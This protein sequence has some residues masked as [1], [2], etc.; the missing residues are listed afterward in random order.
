MDNSASHPGQWI[1]YRSGSGGKDHLAPDVRARI[2]EDEAV[3][4]KAQGLLLCEVRVLVYEREAIPQVSFTEDAALGVESDAS[5][6]AAAVA[7]AR[8]SLADWR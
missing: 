3:H 1:S 4:A 6:L 2:E 5:E 7:R 8:N